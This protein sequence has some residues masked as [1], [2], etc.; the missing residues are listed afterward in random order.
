LLTHLLLTRQLALR[1]D[2]G[3][4]VTWCDEVVR[5]ETQRRAGDESASASAS[6]AALLTNALRDTSVAL[7]EFVA[8]ESSSVFGRSGV[9][10][11]GGSSGGPGGALS[12]ALSGGGRG[13]PVG[14]SSGSAASMQSR[15]PLFV[16][17]LLTQSVAACADGELV[18]AV[19]LAAKADLVAAVFSECE[20][21]EYNCLWEDQS[22]SLHEPKVPGRLAHYRV[23]YRDAALVLETR[24]SM[25]VSFL[26]C[27]VTFYANLAHSLTC[28]P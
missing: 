21:G 5:D 23:W 4:A 24:R 14:G 12:G 25:Q 11:R 28:S 15:V 13:S 8:R 27:T 16:R 6:R 17:Q 1:G 10:A 3:A 18:A 26:L 22:S 19:D 7:I 2:V 9:E 20:L